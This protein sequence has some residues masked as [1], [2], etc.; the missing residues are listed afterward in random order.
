M[1][2]ANI[3]GTDRFRATARIVYHEDAS[4]VWIEVH[5]KHDGVEV[6]NAV[7][8]TRGEFAMAIKSLAVLP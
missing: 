3:R 4:K 8:C 1:R 6:V 7:E 2:E 5:S